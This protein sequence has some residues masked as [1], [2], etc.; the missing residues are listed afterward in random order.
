MSRG[1]K[2]VFQV[3]L[4]GKYYFQ[5]IINAEFDN[6]LFDTKDAFWHCKN[7]TVRNSTVNG[8]YLAWY[9]D[10]L[11]LINC[12]ISGTQPF[13]YCK[14]LKL[15]E[16][17][18]VNTDLCFERSEVQANIT[19]YVESIKNP[20]SGVIR[21]P[22]VGEIIMDIQEAK[23]KILIDSDFCNKENK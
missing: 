5:Y 13:C 10:N 6:C 15:V 8:E 17:E 14:N 1:L 2:A 22:K 16:C 20:L 23:G 4:K 9:S 7:V 18:M 3:L 11:T 21:V 19:S 12:K